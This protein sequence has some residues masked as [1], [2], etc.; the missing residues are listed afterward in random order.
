MKIVFLPQ[1]WDDLMWWRAQDQPSMLKVLDLAQDCTRDPWKGLGKPEPLKYMKS[2]W[3]RRVDN[4]NRLVYV[5][6][7]KGE[8]HQLLI[9]ACRGHYN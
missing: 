6:S 5:V 3:S 4:A 2:Y 7:G 9:V 1:G 8:T